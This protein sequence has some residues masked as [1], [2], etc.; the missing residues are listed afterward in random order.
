MTSY[1]GGAAGR[2]PTS[3]NQA[4]TARLFPE[5][6]ARWPS[7]HRRHGD[8]YPLPRLSR[9][10]AASPLSRRVDSA[11]GALN[12]LA[13]AVF[14]KANP[15]DL[16]LTSV[17]TWMMHDLHRR[18]Q[19]YGECPNDMSELEA[20]SDLT[21]KANLYEQEA[22]NIADYDIGEIKIL[23]RRL[24]P[25]EA[26][27]LA[28]PEA[29]TYL[30]NFT[31]LVERSG[32]ELDLL[33]T[34]GD[35]VKPH[36][37]ER[38]RNSKALRFE[39]YQRLH[40]CGLLTFR[41]RQKAKVGMFTVKKKG[42]RPGNS[43][44]LIVDCRQANYLQRKP[45]TMRLATPAGLTALD[46]G[47]ET[48]EDAG[49]D[50]V[51]GDFKFP[52]PH[53]ETGDVGDC[54][55]N[56]I[57]KE[58][59]S[60]FSTGDIV[61]TEEMR[62]YGIYQDVIYDDVLG[63]DTPVMPGE[64]LFVCF[65]GMPMGW[66]WALYFAQEIISE[67]CRLACGAGPDELIKDKMKAPRIRPGKAPIGVYVDNVHTF[68]GTSHD[69][70]SRMTLIQ[71][72]FEHLGI[73][74]DVDDVSGEATVDTLGLTF[75]FGDDGVTVRAKRE[76]AW[77]LWLTTRALLRRRRISGEM[78]RVWIG[79]IN[80]HFLL[81]R[82]LLSCL[83][84]C[85]AFAS[86]HRHH[87]YPMWDSV[88]KEL[89]LIL[90]LIFTVEKKLSS[91]VNREVHVGDSS[92]RGYGL[93]STHAST[94]HVQQELEHKEKWR[95]IVSDEPSLSHGGGGPLE[96][97][98]DGSGIEFNGS[99]AQ[100]GVGSLT[101]YG[102]QLAERLE[103]EE[104]TP[105]FKSK[106][107][108]L[109]GPVSK[110][111]PTLLE[112]HPIPEVSSRWTD[113]TRWKLLSCG[114]WRLTDEH[115]NVKEARVALMG[116]RRLCR[117]VSNMGTTC[118]S[119]CDNMCATLMFEK[120][121]SGVHALNNL[122]K[123]AAAYQIGC[124][125]QWRLRHIRS[126]DNVADEPSR[127]WGP[128]VSRASRGQRVDRNSLGE[129]FFIDSFEQ[130][131]HSSSSSKPVPPATRTF[132]TSAFLELFAGTAHLSD[133]V[134]KAG[135][136]VLPAFDI[137]KGKHFNLLDKG[138]QEVIIGLIRG[139]HIWC[140]HFGTPCTAWSRARH[141]IKNHKKAR[142]K[143][144]FA[145][146]T[147]LFTARAIREC[148]KH[149][150]LFTLE[151]PTSSRLWQFKPIEDLFRERHVCFF[152]FDLCRYGMPY[153]K[154][155]S[156][157]TNEPSFREL[158]LLCCGG[159][160]HEHLKGTTRVEINGKNVHRNRTRIA[161][162]YPPRLCRQW[163]QI[164]RKIGPPGSKGAPSNREQHEFERLLKEASSSTDRETSQNADAPDHPNWQGEADCDPRILT[165]A[166]QYLSQNPVIFGQFTKADIEREIASKGNRTREQQEGGHPKRS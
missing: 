162:A 48:L 18:V 12:Q 54:F 130:G 17:Q 119:L 87:R 113:P 136:R 64:S 4:A 38:L 111:L 81:A 164:L 49:F 40:Q 134:K 79:H 2:N 106:R 131:N 143:E 112:V 133:A 11:L 147:A 21:S 135:C 32:H 52:T 45:A 20:I 53:V 145:I 155:T 116:L 34:S 41:R 158:G 98:C 5:F 88:R 108:R 150:V 26:K 92:D 56:F 94:K 138:I 30:E 146:A 101:K 97:E 68:G 77:K 39:L 55:Y 60:W 124:S 122:C 156:L 7:T 110:S 90:G 33:R 22:L 16:P 27:D 121:R 103:E 125:I 44:R 105:L 3:S 69:A 166:Q 36:W 161:G 115:I 86:K 14:D 57:I 93:M 31:S 71:R 24:T 28:P 9:P 82:P 51:P 160:V 104:N 47:M 107:D 59:C 6:D 37:D 73:P 75:H 67:Q 72:H 91:P 61:N 85:Y 19:N 42:N 70:S 120:G 62:Q 35:L 154:R 165:E 15:E 109:L 50:G 66:S 127:R 25:F 141:G 1:G 96:A 153:K 132:G 114:P 29:L 80:F 142:R 137:A 151:N 63:R 99:T 95:F 13:T 76:R 8:P 144:H 157:M 10:E 23:Q 102:K 128:D 159:H 74:F 139:K 58:A 118:L 148:I 65:G 83:S 126:E 152:S 123:K 163:A 84:A 129:H 149:G 140:V 43:Q 46:F 117:S 89:K 78:L 100:A